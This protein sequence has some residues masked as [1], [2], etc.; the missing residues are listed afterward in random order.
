M[1][2]GHEWVPTGMK[3]PKH[4]KP[5]LD[6]SESPTPDAKERADL[7]PEEQVN[8]PEQPDFD[9]AEAEQF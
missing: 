3:N 7:D 9:P 1:A 5:S 6:T 8:R 2:R 4:I